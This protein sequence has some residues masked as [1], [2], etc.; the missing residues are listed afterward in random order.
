MSVLIKFSLSSA[1]SIPTPPAGFS[2]SFVD[3]TDGKLYSKNSAGVVSAV[4]SGTVV[5]PLTVTGGVNANSIRTEGE[6]I[7]V[8]VADRWL[9]NSGGQVVLNWENKDLVETVDGLATINWQDRLLRGSNDGVKLNWETGIA[10][11][12]SETNSLNWQNR[13]LSRST[14]QVSI[15]WQ[16]KIAYDDNG[17]SSLDWR[18]RVL[19]EDSDNA[20]S[21]DWQNRYLGDANEQVSINW[22]TRNTFASDGESSMD[23]SARELQDASGAVLRWNNGLGFFGKAPISQPVSSGA[24]SAG[25]S[26]TTTERTMINEMYTA[27]RNLGLIS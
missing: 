13:T 24:V 6:E 18:N 4:L 14:G 25:A 3:S 9:I 5:G 26:Y 16:E 20:I 12:N 8:E 19:R 27:M 17:D 10:I 2:Y 15:S 7:A 11:D 22:E 23:W 1:A 21:I